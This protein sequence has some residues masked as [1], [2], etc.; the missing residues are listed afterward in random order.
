MSDEPIL[1]PGARPTDVELLELAQLCKDAIDAKRALLKGESP[2]A[3]V[4]L[5]E[6]YDAIDALENFWKT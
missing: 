5:R 3:P 4:T 1:L 6:L 2:F